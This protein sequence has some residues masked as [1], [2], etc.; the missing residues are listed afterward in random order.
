MLLMFM[1]AVRYFDDYKSL[2]DEGWLHVTEKTKK[3]PTKVADSRLVEPFLTCLF[4]F[5]E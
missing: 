4:W 2:S 5:R 1:F 3:K